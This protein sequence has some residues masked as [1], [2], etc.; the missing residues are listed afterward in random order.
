[1]NDQPPPDPSA[2][3]AADAAAEP[4]YV[5][6][7]APRLQPSTPRPP[8]GAPVA[9]VAAPPLP[10]W[11]THFAVGLFAVALV[12]HLMF[13]R[14]GWHETGLIGQEFR[15]AQTALTAYWLRENGFSLAY[16]TPLLGKPWAIPMEFPLYQWLAAKLSE[17]ANLE[18]VV[19][20][21]WLGAVSFYAMVPALYLFLGLFGLPPSRRLLAL[22]PVLACPMYLFYTR[23]FLIEAMALSAAVWHAWWVVRVIQGRGLRWAIPLAVAT[24]AVAALVKV[25]TW[26]GVLLPVFAYGVMR[27]AHE[28]PWAEQGSWRR[29]RRLV[30]RSA[31]ATVPVLAIA[32]WWVRTADAIKVH[33]PA[34]EFLLS[35]SLREFN[36]GTLA[37]RFS[38]E[39]WTTVGE[40]WLRHLV[41]DAAWLAL[42]FALALR[43]VVRRAALWALA[44]FLA[45]LLVFSNLYFLHDYYFYANGLFLCLAVGL[46]LVRLLELEAFPA[47]VRVALLLIVPAAQLGAY[48]AGYYRWQ[49]LS[50]PG[51]SG[52]T[53]AIRAL[54]DPDDVLVIYGDDWTSIIPY[55][56]QRRALMIPSWREPDE[57]GTRRSLELLADEHIPLLLVRERTRHHHDLVRR[58][59][60]DLEMHPEPLL[61]WEDKIDVYAR[62]DLIEEYAANLE[63]S[64]FHNVVLLHRA[65]PATSPPLDLSLREVDPRRNRAAFTMMSHPPFRYI[66]PYG[67]SVLGHEGRTVL[68]AHTPSEFH[69]RIPPGARTLRLVYGTIDDAWQRGETDG[70]DWE[71]YHLTAEGERTTL[72]E[73]FRDPKFVPTDRGRHTVRLELPADPGPEDIL[74]VRSGPGPH[75]HAAW[76]WAYIE[77]LEFR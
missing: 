42:V 22:V 61:R 29:L 40:V 23:A 13:L 17:L 41:P 74:V 9:T 47:W 63:G 4:D 70:M 38:P 30:L 49:R 54:T 37:Q 8:P 64:L 24:G 16:E 2:R 1:M 68:L 73:V 67:L 51:G 27:V 3:A 50:F 53:Q 69:F 59:I 44:A 57:E 39:F 7:R 45:P 20:G 25:T 6:T 65:G 58:R 56:S 77:S 15:Q 72:Y 35:S 32:L 10:Q 71:V 43:G 46:G 60:A 76:D 52:L 28:G 5:P 36:F 66:A 19:A 75:G 12:V 33:N 11:R 21:R 26:A 14:V 48:H 55:Y 18:L 62:A 34:A 31:G